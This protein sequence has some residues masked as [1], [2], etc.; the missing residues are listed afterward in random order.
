MRRGG[1]LKRGLEFE[2]VKFG[3]VVRLTMRIVGSH[4]TRM[5]DNF[6]GY[7]LRRLPIYSVFLTAVK[8]QAQADISVG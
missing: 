5:E 3:R 4:M 2:G 7:L 6:S 8:P 1:G